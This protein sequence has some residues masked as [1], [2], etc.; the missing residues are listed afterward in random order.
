MN[1][2]VQDRFVKCIYR[3]YIL[4][5]EHPKLGLKTQLYHRLKDEHHS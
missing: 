1:I 2:H 3:R 5:Y 4:S